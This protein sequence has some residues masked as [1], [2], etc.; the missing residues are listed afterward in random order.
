MYI[1]LGKRNCIDHCHTTGQ[2]RGIL[3]WRVNK[4]IGLLEKACPEDIVGLLRGLVAYYEH[5][6]AEQVI[7]KRYG[8]IGLAKI[9]KKKKIYGPPNSI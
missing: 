7:G 2:C 9:N 8:L 3:E 6:P 1:L 4:A 5:F